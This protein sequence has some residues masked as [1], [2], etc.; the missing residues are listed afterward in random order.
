MYDRDIDHKVEL[1]FH[2]TCSPVS[3]YPLSCTSV[4]AL[5]YLCIYHCSYI[6]TLSIIYITYPTST[7]PLLRRNHVSLLFRA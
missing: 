1:N 5:P 6:Y 2:S 7:L 3:L 4:S